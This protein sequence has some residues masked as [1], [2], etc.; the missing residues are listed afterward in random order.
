MP[1]FAPV[2]RPPPPSRCTV[3]MPLPVGGDAV[4]LAQRAEPSLLRVQRCVEAQHPPPCEHA[5]WPVVQP[6]GTSPTTEVGAGVLVPR[7][8]RPLAQS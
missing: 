4:M 2:E 7:H 1:A 6:A 3:E 8:L 5:T